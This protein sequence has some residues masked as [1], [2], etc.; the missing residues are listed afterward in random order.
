MA[1]HCT[2]LRHL[3]AVFVLALCLSPGAGFAAPEL[4][5]LRADLRELTVSG[6]SSG[7]YMAVQFQVAHSKLVRG[8]GILA[9]GPYDCAQGSTW[10][11][12]TRCM[13]PSG[14]APLPTVAELRAH[15]EMLARSGRI[16][17]L[18][19]LRDDR[20]WLLSGG[21]DE[22]VATTV[23]ERL[24]A[25]YAEWLPPT[26][27]RFVRVPEAGHAM[28]SVADPQ[29][30]ACS[31]TGSPFINRCGDLDP[32][33]EMLAQM[34]GPLPPGTAST[35]GEM[36]TF[37][38][39][40]FADG[41]PLDAGLADEAYAYVPQV[42]R[43]QPCRVHVAFHG[44]RQSAAQIG[45]R[46]VEGAGYNAWAERYRLIVLYP[47]T[48]PRH[49]LAFGS[50]KWVS[51]PFACWDWWGY[52]GSDYPTREGRQIKAVRA[53]LERLAGARQP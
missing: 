14:W 31:S 23:V 38:Q 15:A 18:D 12:L 19:H 46:F 36:L 42:C 5:A 2:A 4:P 27:L 9:G 45:R 21:Q 51:N 41:K 6:I 29:A 47:Q 24:A 50:S 34:L 16:D 11:A 28:I 26:A 48:V 35:P 49:G 13:S 37:N 33:G 32:A 20:V 53:M 40:P 1:L 7:G 25:F 52:S 30:N 39:R 22:T 10:R 43:S 17:P 8:A 3:A 44:C